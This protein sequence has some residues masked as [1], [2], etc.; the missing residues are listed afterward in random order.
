MHAY[1]EY[2]Q[3]YV[4][5]LNNL[6]EGGKFSNDF[7]VTTLGRI[8]RKLWIDELP[9]LINLLRGDL[10]V[11]GVRPLSQHYFNLYSRELQE[12]RI[13]YKPGLVPPFYADLPKTLQEIMD[14]EMKYLEQYEQHPIITDIKYFFKAFYNIIFKRARSN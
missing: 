5:Q 2:L 12:K 6:Q 13:K 9:M 3:A 10:K 11:V 8:F 14:S 7:R 1:S 4:F